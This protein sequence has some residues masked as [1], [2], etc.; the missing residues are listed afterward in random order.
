[1]I[2]TVAHRWPAA[3]K[4]SFNCC[5]QLLQLIIRV[6]GERTPRIILS[7]EGIIQGDPMAMPLYGVN[8][9]FLGKQLKSDL[10]EPMQ[11][12]YADN[13]SATARGRAARPLIQSLGDLGPSRGVFLY[14]E[15]I[16]YVRPERFPEAAAK[17]AT[18][19]TNLNHEA[20][21]FSHG[22]YV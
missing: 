4:F 16:H 12:W 9:A 1:M 6:P 8:M 2:W 21:S 3:S 5:S 14:P 19:G 17:L 18:S 13:F 15:K 22:G 20:R 11:V 10:P 7:K